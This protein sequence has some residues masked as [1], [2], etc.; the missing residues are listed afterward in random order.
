[1]RSDLF[2]SLQEIVKRILCSVSVYVDGGTD[3]QDTHVNHDD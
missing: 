1:M 3:V 2:R